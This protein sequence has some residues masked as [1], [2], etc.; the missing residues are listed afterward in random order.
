MKTKK[1]QP[2]KNVGIAPVGATKAELVWLNLT[3]QTLQ[4]ILD[5]DLEAGDK[6]WDAWADEFRASLDEGRDLSSDADDWLSEKYRNQYVLR[7]AKVLASKAGWRRT[8]PK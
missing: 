6:A 2:T 7:Q 3:P 4:K 8:H 5:L 1:Y